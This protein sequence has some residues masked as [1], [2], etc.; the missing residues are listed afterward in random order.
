MYI[1][2]TESLFCTPETLSINYTSIKKTY[3]RSRH[4]FLTIVNKLI[5]NFK[6]KKIIIFSCLTDLNIYLFIVFLELHLQ[7]MEVPRLGVESELQLPA[8]IIATATQDPSCIC[9][10]YHS[11]QQRQI[12][13]PLSKAKDEPASS[14]I[15]VRFINR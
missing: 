9:D 11:S 6:S 15:L 13:N 3:I 5:E 8:Y 4:D 14:W 1:Y 7:H 10:L 12:L 2:I